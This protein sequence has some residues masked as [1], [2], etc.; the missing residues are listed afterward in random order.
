MPDEKLKRKPKFTETE[1]DALVEGV[2]AKKKTVF[3]KFTDAVHN[4]EKRIAWQKITDSINSVS[5]TLRT[6]DDVRRKWSD[7]TIVTWDKRGVDSAARPSTYSS[8]ATLHFDEL[9][10]PNEDSDSQE[11]QC[12]DFFGSSNLGDEAESDNPAPAKPKSPWAR[13]IPEGK[14]PLSADSSAT[15]TK[16]KP[17]AAT[18]T[19]KGSV[20]KSSVKRV[21]VTAKSTSNDTSMELVKIERERLS[22]EKERL[23][24][25]KQRLAIEKQKL[26]L[27]EKFLAGTDNNNETSDS[28]M[29]L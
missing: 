14:P 9:D 1:L 27:L 19:P 18:G 26:V 29:D 13:R 2:Q 21:E 16:P 10:S 5:K 20:T 23:E 4:E 6:A 28:L 11:V 25:E 22:V 24:L 3:N 15:T 7:W 12:S 17:S 8:S